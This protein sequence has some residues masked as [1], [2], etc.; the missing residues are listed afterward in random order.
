M[1][2][3]FWEFTPSLWPT[4]AALLV[5]PLFLY[6]GFWQLDRADQKLTLHH[7]FESRQAESV[8]SLN[9]ED[10]LQNNF[11]ELHWRKVTIE[12]VFSRDINVLLDNQVQRGV[13][14]YFV[15]TPF[16]IND[17]DTWV[18]VNRGWVPVGASRDNAP[19]INAVEEVLLIVGNIKSPPE[20][21]ILLAENIVEPL[22]E[23]TVRV[24]KL[25]LSGI[26]EA[27]NLEFLPYVV[28]LSPE[29]TAGFARSWK[30]PGSGEEKNLGY[31]FQWFA[32]A[33]AIFVIYLVLNIKRA[34]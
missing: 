13:A 9:N 29:S 33:T 30:A 28:R 8:I 14:G 20:T 3:A 2:F 16:K 12:G 6:L 24:Q 7:E 32:M 18:L 11:D 25:E 15:Y 5:F 34:K 27:L 17:Q 21:G 23:R 31:A 19:E 4:L 10:A 26:E 1:R 22:N